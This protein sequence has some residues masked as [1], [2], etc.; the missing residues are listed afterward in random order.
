[1]QEKYI[2]Q[3][4]A[5]QAA[6][7]HGYNKKKGNICFWTD[8]LKLRFQLAVRAQP[9]QRLLPQSLQVWKMVLLIGS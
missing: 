5:G 8:I 4:K 9:Y 6:S 3:K 2:Q 1:L 7:P